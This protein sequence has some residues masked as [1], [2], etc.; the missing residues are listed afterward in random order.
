MK[1]EQLAVVLPSRKVTNEDVLKEIEFHSKDFK[2]DLEK[3][4]K[5]I[6]LTLKR[7]GSNIRA[8]LGPG[9][10]PLSL[11]TQVCQQAIANLGED[12]KIDL[13]ISAS[14]YP[15][16][17]EPATA[18]LI[19]H[20]TG[21]DYAEC[22]DVKEACDGWMKAIKI[23]SA[24]IESGLYRR[25]MVVNGEFSMRPGFAV[26]PKIFQLSTDS[27]LEWR[28]PAFTLGEAATAVILGV[29]PDNRWSFTNVTRNDLFDLC[30]ITVPWHNLYP[31]NSHRVA[32]DGPGIFTSYGKE[33]RDHGLPLVVKTFKESGINPKNV[34]ILFTHSSSKRDWAEAARRI[35]LSDKIYDI[36]TRCGN[37]VSAAVPAAMAL[38]IEDGTLK[39]GHQ[40]AALVASAG[41]TFSTAY[42]KF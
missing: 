28:F 24:F 17:M 15:E 9:E 11:M 8:W 10:S 23:A 30:S 7:S 5:M 13:L 2:G 39:R 1:I 14:V 22:F 33:L 4:L 37:V 3:T 29:D 41:M 18:N 16:L 36:Y 34:D 32:K 38:A 31:I 20:K 12:N 42:F 19:A 26:Y 25:V 35:D 40:V 6:E 27:E 21:L